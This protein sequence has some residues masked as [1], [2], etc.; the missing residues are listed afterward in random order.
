[1]D[2]SSD[3]KARDPS[4]SERDGTKDAPGQTEAAASAPDETKS[5]AAKAETTANAA[6][7]PAIGPLDGQ[8]ISPGSSRAEGEAEKNAKDASSATAQPG[9]SLILIP[10]VTRNTDGQSSNE[11]FAAND[12]ADRMSRPWIK[13]GWLRYA[14]P[15]A[16]GFCLFGVGV[17]TGGRFFGIAAPVN[18]AMSPA[19]NAVQI[20]QADNE[21]NE[22]RR[23]N[24]KLSD[25]IHRLEIRFDSMRIAVQ[26]K[27]PEELRSLKKGLDGLKAS[28]DAAKTETH[29]SMA[30]VTAR[31]DRL[32]QDEA[33]LQQPQP[34]AKA[35][36]IEPKAAAPVATGMIAR[37][38]P[39]RPAEV[40]LATPPALPQGQA[41][42]L[43]PA[44]EPKK[45]LQLLSD[46]VVRD[47]YR[48]VALVDGP[49]G[50]IEVMRGETI[51][52]A[53]TV[54]SIEHGR[55]GWI[56]VTNRGIV[57]SLRD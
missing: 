41:Q 19:P 49:T 54:K 9:T 35:N 13:E 44:P 31:L 28:L 11:H 39:P 6:Q 55:G 27:T 38:A 17:A 53:G 21:R 20:A 36:H 43:G 26:T 7:G 47:V 45:K 25:E 14:A 3:D 22:M 52:G 2:F 23:L 15:A 12:A 46:W 33:K 40:A 16:L 4:S 57:G 29:A 10:P 37:A 18:H 30:Q 56:V 8:V 42:P 51:P 24:K 48:G 50:A 1:M 34:V 5:D 32:Q